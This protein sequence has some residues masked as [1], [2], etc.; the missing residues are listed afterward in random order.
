[1]SNITAL[2]AYLKFFTP[3][4]AM[5]EVNEI[6]INRPY[7]IWVERK[8]H[9]KRFEEPKF[10]MDFLLQF[11]SL[12]GEYNQ[13]EISPECPVL[14]S[15]LPDGSRVQ[16]VI[17]PACAK[18][19]FICAIRRHAVKQVPLKNYFEDN[20]P[21]QSFDAQS[22]SL[23]SDQ[24]LLAIYEKRD[25][26]LFLREAVLARKNII[27]SGGTSTGK[28]TFLNVLLQE[29]PQSERILTIETDREVKTT[30]QNCVHLISSRRGQKCC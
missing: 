8:G 6:C 5:E 20:A 21:L 12:V 30:H 28:T 17:E 23:F 13:R 22:V 9:F 26:M 27:I 4:F 10:S 11:A 14:S 25:Y 1:M 2:N 16:F 3:Y 7:E 15:V 19:T 29:I 18:D 24:S